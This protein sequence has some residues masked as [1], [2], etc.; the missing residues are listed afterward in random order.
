MKARGRTRGV[1]PHHE[2][3][4]VYRMTYFMFIP[5]YVG[6]TKAKSGEGESPPETDIQMRLQTVCRQLSEEKRKSRRCGNICLPAHLSITG[7]C[8]TSH[9]GVS[10]H[11]GCLSSPYSRAERTTAWHTGD[12][13]ASPFGQHTNE[14]PRTDLPYHSCSQPTNGRT[15]DLDMI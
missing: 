7:A 5:P 11:V 12:P 13:K 6:R 10:P 1:G 14:Q 8:T 15:G 2:H 4:L 3:A 9:A